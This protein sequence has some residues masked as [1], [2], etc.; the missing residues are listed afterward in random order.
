MT[1]ADATRDQGYRQK[2]APRQKPERPVH[3]CLDLFCGAGRVTEG[4]R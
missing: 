3:I 1:M 2:G 4:F